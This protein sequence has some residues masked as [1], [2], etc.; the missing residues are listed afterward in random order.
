MPTPAVAPRVPVLRIGTHNVRG[1]LPAHTLAASSQHTRLVALDRV[2]RRERYH[3]VMLQE[4]H[5]PA[6][7][8]AEADHR[9]DTLA[10][11]SSMGGWTAF[12]APAVSSHSAGVAILVRNSII[13]Q[14]LTVHSE[15][16]HFSAD[17]HDPAFGRFLSLPVNWHGQA[18]HL[19]CTYMPNTSPDQR[20]LITSHLQ[21]L[22]SP[23]HPNS[24]LHIVGGDFN[25]VE[26]CALDRSSRAAG[27]SRPDEGTSVHLRTSCPDLCDVF[28]LLHPTRKGHTHAGVASA[29]PYSSR[30]DRFYVSSSL[31]SSCTTCAVGTSGS[32][33][34]HL[35]LS[36]TLI[37][38]RLPSRPPLSLPHHSTTF[39]IFRDLASQFTAFLEAAFDTAAPGAQRPPSTS[40][41]AAVLQWWSDFKPRLYRE[42][43]RLNADARSRLRDP[44]N[45][46]AQACQGLSAALEVHEQA[47][48]S[49]APAALQGVLA[50]QRTVVQALLQESHTTVQAHRLQWLR[51]GER[52]SPAMT[53]IVRPRQCDRRV[54]ALRRRDGTLEADPQR[55]SQL[56]AEHWARI[57]SPPPTTPAAQQQVLAAVRQA[58][59][60]RRVCIDPAAAPA[61]GDTD[62]TEAEVVA[63]LKA[64]RRGKSPGIDGLPTELYRAFSEQFAPVL[65][66]LYSAIGVAQAMPRGFTLGVIT[67]LHKT[68]C[69]AEPS[70]YRPITLLNTDYRCLAKVLATRLKSVLD[71]VIEPEQTAFLSGRDIGENVLLM[72]LLPELLQRQNSTAVVAALDFYKAYDTVCR[73][74]LFRI[75]DAMGAGAGFISWV[76]LLLSTTPAIAAVNGCQSRQAQFAAGMRQGCPLSPALY[77]FVGQALLSFLKAAPPESGLGIDVAGERLVAL[78]HADDTEALLASLEAWPAFAARMHV[79]ALATGQRLNM[80]KVLLMLLNSATSKPHCAA[81]QEHARWRAPPAPDPPDPDPPPPPG[82]HAP[83][84]PAQ[85]APPPPAPPSPPPSPPRTPPP[86]PG[87]STSRLRP[88]SSLLQSRWRQTAASTA[89]RAHRRSRPSLSP[90]APPAPPALPI[91]H[92]PTLVKASFKSLGVIFSDCCSRCSCP[93]AAPVDWEA[94]TAGVTQRLTSLS[95][96][97]TLSPFGLATAASTYAESPVHYHAEFGGLP[98]DWQLEL[99][100]R[101]RARL[102]DGRWPR[103]NAGYQPRLTGI[104]GALQ[105]GS[106][107]AGGFGALPF[108]QHVQSRWARWGLRLARSGADA[109]QRDRWWV[110]VARALLARRHGLSPHLRADPLMLLSECGS[111]YLQIPSSS[112]LPFGCPRPAPATAMGRLLAGLRALPPLLAAAAGTLP[113]PGHWC[114][115]MPLW[116]NALLDRLVALP[117]GARTFY[118]AFGD[119]A[120]RTN[121]KVATVGDALLWLG[122]ASA[123]TSEQQW[124]GV[125][126]TEFG[127]SLPPIA[128]GSAGGMHELRGLLVALTAALPE[129]WADAA[130]RSWTA[131]LQ[132]PAA[133]RL[134]AQEV[135]VAAL[136]WREIEVTVGEGPQPPPAAPGPAPPPPQAAPGPAPPSPAAAPGPSG[137]AESSAAGAQR[138]QREQAVPPP[139]PPPAPQPQPHAQQPAQPACTLSLAPTLIPVSAL[140]VKQ[141]TALQLASLQMLRAQSQGLFVLAA[142]HGVSPAAYSLAQGAAALSSMRLA[143]WRLHWENSFKAPYWRLMQDAVRHPHNAAMRGGSTTL[144]PEQLDVL[145]LAADLPPGPPPGPPPVPPPAGRRYTCACGQGECSRE[146]HF[147]ECP[148]ARAVF[149]SL[150]LALVGS[151]SEPLQRYHVWLGVCPPGATTTVRPLV[152]PLVCLSAVAAMEAGR[153]RLREAQVQREQELAAHAGLRQ[154]LITEHLVGPGGAPLRGPPPSPVQLASARA[155]A[156][157]WANLQS[158][159]AKGLPQR[160]AKRWRKGGVLETHPFVGVQADL[161]LVLNDPR[162]APAGPAGVD[163]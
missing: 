130:R 156:E 93:L 31:T 50:A 104:P 145:R 138:M 1:L 121:G 68:G 129:G 34:D 63:A 21:P 115:A 12:W 137:G 18:L 144:L 109:E 140:T 11:V 17:P 69:R 153:K 8:C 157:L 148:V 39:A 155:V 29:G 25:F 28:R 120:L 35:P 52:P 142:L 14:G 26:D 15:R 46:V 61:L 43:N 98:L 147:H 117:D 108:Q 131:A 86:G 124:R 70:N 67:T 127:S 13:G 5:V 106:P 114:A 3:I 57:S 162:P 154:T 103:P 102:V 47:P 10:S 100:S 74:F 135:V 159:A 119:A 55:M 90:P 122:W 152:W 22:P 150:Q 59:Q 123:G 88:L 56:V 141:G 16:V 84:A 134:R 42:L 83:P 112:W 48:E 128:L 92:A 76:K 2:W 82:P 139:P 73:Q 133:W 91:P 54:S 118:G 58:A 38:P 44:T 160:V 149:D 30:L 81:C 66:Q 151:D 132:D 65:A 146:H 97:H 9:L 96:M 89:R 80:D 37:S 78:Q 62:I 143:A 72:Q 36:L 4:T 116:G 87:P 99:M 158:F 105:V 95:R 113:H 40:P 136:G 7:R 53:R 32:P 23:T 33:S 6:S 41:P 101:E 77:L 27:L 75:M 24:A 85:D 71:P 51:I 126:A 125:L 64:T 161:T 94:R 49:A 19:T 20:R 60:Q 45:A 79:F 163:L 107:A 110:R 111:A